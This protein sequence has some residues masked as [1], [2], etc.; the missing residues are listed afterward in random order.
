MDLS[1]KT[2]RRLLAGALCAALAAGL[3]ACGAPA[4]SSSETE[5]PTPA[6]IEDAAWV[7]PAEQ[8]APAGNADAAQ[9]DALAYAGGAIAF[10]ADTDGVETG[11]DAA[12]WRG[13]QNFA[14]TFGYR[15][16]SFQAREDTA[17]AREEALREA[18]ESG[19]PL[20]VCR[21]N[22]MASALYA[23]QRN[24][25]TISYLLLEGEPHSSDYTAYETTNNTHCVLFAV[26]QAGYL[27][28]YAA[29]MDGYTALGFAGA[30]SM[31]ETVRYCTGLLQGADDAA[32]LQGEQVSVDV[33][34]IGS[35]QASD[36]VTARMGSWY[37]EGV[38][39]IMSCGGD[40]VESCIE[41][42]RDNGGLV[43]NAAWDAA[44]LDDTVLTS[45]L[46]NYSVT[47][48]RQLYDFFAAGSWGEKAG[49]TERVS[50]ADAAVSLPRTGWPFSGFALE[51]YE[52]L[53]AQLCEG[54]VRVERYSDAEALPQTP[55]VT[56][57][58]AN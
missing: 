30:D 26:E 44:E 40:L 51:E 56:V 38:Q 25:P 9:P 52:A 50:A 33:W 10:V 43:L 35:G 21:G 12:V 31:P 2:F 29:V 11:P 23:I 46:L 27:A 37:S 48:Q 55:N 17:E 39:L 47:T 32:T 1:S 36:A 15:A 14:S 20:V 3:C 18:A 13:V 19:A 28:G 22:A 24:Y 5:A 53:Y 7:L 34:Y 54:T 41:A 45:A 16:L 8:A 58:L 49:Q 4:A 57:E 42:A 6:Q